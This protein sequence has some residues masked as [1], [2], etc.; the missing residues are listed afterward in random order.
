MLFSF[1]PNKIMLFFYLI[2]FLELSS[3]SCI[4]E[5]S[6]PLL[7]ANISFMQNICYIYYL[8]KEFQKWKQLICR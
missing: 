5:F 1:V 3:D 2:F 6:A 7:S 8:I 4:M